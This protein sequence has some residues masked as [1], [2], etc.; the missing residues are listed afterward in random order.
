MRHGAV[1][2]R[3]S[4]PG[5]RAFLLTIVC[6]KAAHTNIRHGFGASGRRFYVRSCAPAC[7]CRH[8]LAYRCDTLNR[9]GGPQYPRGRNLPLVTCLPKRGSRPARTR[10]V[11]HGA[12]GS[13]ISSPGWRARPPTA[14]CSKL[15]HTNIYDEFG[16]NGGRFFACSCCPE[17]ICGR[18]PAHRFDRMRRA[19]GPSES[20]Q[21]DP[22]LGYLLFK[23]RQH[24]GKDK[25][26]ESSCRTL[27]NRVSGQNNMPPRNRVLETTPDQYLRRVWR[28]R[29][30]LFR[31]K[32]LSGV[33]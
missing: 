6:S 8:E 29:Q 7:N 23:A 3:I 12:V 33:L 16:A 15:A 26:G 27:E 22:H 10:N 9:A 24:T 19:G 4:S 28:K 32:L 17:C 14:V 30:T 20:P 2:S 21:A 5:W 18:V 13:R 25:T 1:G 31:L 11:M